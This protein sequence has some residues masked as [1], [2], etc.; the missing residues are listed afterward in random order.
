VIIYRQANIMKYIF[1]LLSIIA[2]L[3]SSCSKEGNSQLVKDYIGAYEKADTSVLN[4]LLDDRVVVEYAGQNT[5]FSKA[6]VLERSVFNSSFKPKSEILE[7]SE[8]EGNVLVK[9][10]E[11]DA[12]KD[13][14]GIVLSEFNYIYQVE[15][16]QITKISIDTLDNP[17]VSYKSQDKLFGKRMDSFMVD[18][19]M[20]DSLKFKLIRS[21]D[22]AGRA[23]LMEHISSK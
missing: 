13:F 14:F 22:E 17:V 9:M 5:G 2:L 1:P 11:T 20:N 19:R 18:L 7:I 23:A 10:S 21:F 12:L 16:N 3:F 6:D 4:A 15:E 8:E